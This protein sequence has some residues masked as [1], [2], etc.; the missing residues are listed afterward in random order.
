MAKRL[1]GLE[2][3]VS[4]YMADLRTTSQNGS[5]SKSTTRR[6]YVGKK[7][8]EAPYTSNQP[9]L[10]IAPTSTHRPLCKV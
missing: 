2:N 9:A 5:W 3:T 4:K 1:Q 7:S 8:S 6:N 10:C